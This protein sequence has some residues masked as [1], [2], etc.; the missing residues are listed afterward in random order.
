MN[1]QNIKKRSKKQRMDSA[2]P[3]FRQKGILERTNHKSVHTQALRWNSKAARWARYFGKR[4]LN[5]LAQW[6]YLLLCIF[7]GKEDRQHLIVRRS[8]KE[9]IIYEWKYQSKYYS[10]KYIKLLIS[11]GLWEWRF[12]GWSANQF[13]LRKRI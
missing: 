6:N 12:R 8:K 9:D 3:R 10:Q 5:F 7:L 4:C 11:L 2:D 13:N 1:L